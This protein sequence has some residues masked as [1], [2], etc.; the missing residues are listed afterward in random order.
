M[1]KYSSRSDL[2][3]FQYLKVKTTLGVLVM[4]VFS[5]LAPSKFPS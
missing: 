2:S 4:K 3:L 5:S 1:G